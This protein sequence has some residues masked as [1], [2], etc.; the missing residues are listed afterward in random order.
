MILENAVNKV[1][2]KLV[3]L[4]GKH[5]I[6]LWG[7]SEATV[8]LYQY[9]DLIKYPISE[10]VDNYKAGLKVF[11][12]IVKKPKDIA[13]NEVD[14]VVVAASYREEQIINEL[15]QVYGYNRDIVSIKIQD[16]NKPFY[17]HLLQLEL[18]V[19]DEYKNIIEQNQKFKNIHQGQRVF[20]L[21]TGSSVKQ[22]DLCKLQNEKVM[23]VSNFF[24]HKDLKIIKPDYYCVAPL[25]YNEKYTQRVVHDWLEELEKKVGDSQYIFCINEKK[26]I[27]KYHLFSNK[28]VNYV[29]FG[30]NSPYYDDVDLTNAILPV[31]SVPIMCIQI[32]MYM[33]FKE[34]Y[35]VGTEHSELR[36][37]EYSYFYDR[38]ES[39]FGDKDSCVDKN[40]QIICT[41]DQ[42]LTATYNLWSQYKLMKSIAETKSIKIYNATK[43]GMLDL[44]ERVDFEKLF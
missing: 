9:T 10:I 43:G 38:K 6:I 17:E 12:K 37:K 26:I 32:A 29:Y 27:D 30:K 14:S 13:W 23:A 31:Q 21:C 18:Q 11:G 19:P 28:E 44:F 33:G 35:L 42:S 41:T 24:L 8:K 40:S 25:I 15:Q 1:N 4:D 22:M 34:I 16:D 7:A 36:T 2:E 3:R 20:I 39:I 5:R